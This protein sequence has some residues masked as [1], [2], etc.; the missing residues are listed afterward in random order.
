V[1]LVGVLQQPGGDVP[2][3]S[4]IIF[5]II[6][7]LLLIISTICFVLFLFTKQGKN[8]LIFQD[9]SLKTKNEQNS[10]NIIE[11]IIQKN[12]INNEIDKSNLINETNENKTLQNVNNENNLIENNKNNEINEN[13]TY[14]DTIRLI[15]IQCKIYF[16]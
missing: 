4:V 5:S 10:N 7:T 13:F 11:K 2:N 14:F 9:E 6:I 3:F 8:E 16:I 15:F 1:G 12:N